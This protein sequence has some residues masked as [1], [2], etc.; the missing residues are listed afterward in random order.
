MLSLCSPTKST[1]DGLLWICGLALSLGLLCCSVGCELHACNDDSQCNGFRC[2]KTEKICQTSCQSDADCN[3]PQGYVCEIVSSGNRC[4]CNPKDTS[5]YCRF[6]CFNMEDC[7]TVSGCMVP[8]KDPVT[9]KE[10]QRSQCS[11]CMDP[12]QAC[13]E[14]VMDPNTGVDTGQRKRK[15]D[16]RCLD[17]F[18]DQKL[19]LQNEWGALKVAFQKQLEAW[20]TSMVAWKKGEGG[21]TPPEL[22]VLPKGSNTIESFFEIVSW[23]QQVTTWKDTR[24]KAWIE[25]PKDAYLAKDEFQRDQ[26]LQEFPF[27][28]DTPSPSTPQGTPQQ[29]QMTTE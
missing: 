14:V 28:P 10:T 1:K 24:L 27:V 18:F 22:P 29:C 25:E 7:Q 15:D 8:S 3:Q 26:A 2:N 21:A 16:C 5:A 20:K 12:C 23:K 17:P 13:V 19:A 4:V 9:G 6:Q 11:M